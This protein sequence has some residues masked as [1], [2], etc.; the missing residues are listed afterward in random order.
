MGTIPRWVPCLIWKFMKPVA[1]CRY[2]CWFFFFFFLVSHRFICLHIF[3]MYEASFRLSELLKGI[4]KFSVKIMKAC[5]RTFIFFTWI[6]A[7]KHGFSL[8]PYTCVRTSRIYGLSIKE[9]VVFQQNLLFHWELCCPYIL[10]LAVR[11]SYYY[12]P[13]WVKRHRWDSLPA[14]GLALLAFFVDLLCL[15]S[16]SEGRLVYCRRC[17]KYNWYLKMR[18]ILLL[19]FA[20]VV[21]SAS[22][23]WLHSRIIWE[24]Y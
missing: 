2:S 22:Q 9:H 17:L 4:N 6:H 12:L 13:F 16:S 23:L 14:G 8:K 24:R 7:G 15:M 10:H 18:N 19:F 1:V 5:I 20:A 11:S 21:V 3:K